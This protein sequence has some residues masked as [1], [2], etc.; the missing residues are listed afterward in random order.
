MRQESCLENRKDGYYS[1]FKP[2]LVGSLVLGSFIKIRLD[3]QQLASEQ[4]L[5]EDEVGGGDGGRD[6]SSRGEDES[7]RGGEGGAGPG[8]EEQRL[9]RGGEQ[10]HSQSQSNQTLR[11][12]I[13]RMINL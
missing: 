11:H 1:M 6:A 13:Y 9:G 4:R 8:G 12:G 5:A 7:A 2:F 10:A 3:Q